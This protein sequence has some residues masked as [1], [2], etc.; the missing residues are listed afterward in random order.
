MKMPASFAEF[1]D[2]LQKARIKDGSFCKNELTCIHYNGLTHAMIGWNA[3]LYDL[4]LFAQRLASLTEEQKKGMDALLKI[5]QNHRVA[6]IPLN[7]LINLTYNTDIC[8]FAPRVSNHEELGAFL[9]ANEMLSNEAMALLDTTE[10][11]SGFQERLLELLGEQHQEDHGGVFTDF[12]YAELGGEIKDIYVCQSN[13][14]ACFHRSDAPVVLEVRKG[15]FNDPSYDNDKTAV[16]N[17]PAADAGIWRAVE[18]VDAASVD[19]CAF[20][21]VD[22]LIPFLR[23]AINNAIDD[24]DGIEQADEFAKRLAQIEREWPESDMVKY[25]ALLSVV[26]HPSLQDAT[27]LMGEIDQ[28]EL[29]PEVA[30]TWGYAEMMFREKYSALPEELFQT[31]QAAQIG[32]KMLDDRLGVITEYG[33]IRRKD[34]Q[35]LPVFQPEQEIGQGLEIMCAMSDQ[36]AALFDKLDGFYVTKSEHDWL[37]RRFSNMTEKEKILF[38]GA[39]ELEKPQEIGHVMR[40]ASQL[41]CYDLFYGAG[42][43]AAL[44]KFVMESIECSSDAARPFLNAEHL[45]AAYHQSQNGAFCNGHYVRNIKL[46]DPFVEED[47]TLQPVAGDYAIRVKLASRSNMEGIWVGFPDSGEYID[48]NHPDELLLGLDSLQAESLSECI[49]LE[50]DCC[51]PQLTG[52]LDQYDSASELVRHAID[53]GYVWAEQ[54]QGAPH[55]LDKWQAV[56]ELED[57]H[58]LDLALDLAQ[59][60]QHYEFF[61]RGMDLAAYGRE[62]AVRNGVIPPS[63]LITDAFDGAAYAEANMGQYGLSTTDHG[64]VAWNGGERRYEYSQPEH[65]SPALSI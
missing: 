31:P 52:I 2:A 61:P 3:N 62:L 9:Y 51:L 43:E 42:D 21:C 35:P 19:E 6:P 47:P 56:L 29:R 46:A 18:K 38:Q 50:V 12:G 30:Q 53:F 45:G 63:R 7:Q 17:L 41:D 5:K 37:E 65:H 48:S 10:E 24:E 28:Y 40:I 16:L 8:C 59:N 60:L 44:G 55:W 15:F 26:D 34:G 27:R 1:S 39:M 57:C 49:A 36:N 25:K 13:E 64:Y 32:Q 58:R 14:T 33:L 11:G 54:G 20:R 4:N 23:D 22:C